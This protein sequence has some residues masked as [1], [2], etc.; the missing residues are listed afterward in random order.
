MTLIQNIREGAMTNRM[1]NIQ[2][3]R[4]VRLNTGPLVFG[5]ELIGVGSVLLMA[6]FAVGGM[7]MMST[8]RR[9]IGDQEMP[10]SEIVKHHWRKTVAATTAGAS[11]WQNH[12]SASS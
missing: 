9:W 10:P 11:A 7:T 2:K 3:L 1:A 5:A 4:P 8:A 6:G 12:T